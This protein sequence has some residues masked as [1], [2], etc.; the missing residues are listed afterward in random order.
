MMPPSS[1]IKPTSNILGLSMMVSGGAGK[2]NSKENPFNKV[3]TMIQNNFTPD[4]ATRACTLQF[5]S[6]HPHR[7]IV[8]VLHLHS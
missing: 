7:Y 3:N 4:A 6:L 1:K 2:K 5:C 8:T